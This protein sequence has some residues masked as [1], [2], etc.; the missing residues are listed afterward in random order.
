L[1]ASQA[2]G[3]G[4]RRYFLSADANEGG[5]GLGQQLA[6]RRAAGRRGPARGELNAWILANTETTKAA[7][8]AAAARTKD[9]QR[10]QQL[11]QLARF[12]TISAWDELLTYAPRAGVDLAKIVGFTGTTT[13]PAAARP[14]L[15]QPT[16]NVASGMLAS[17]AEPLASLAP[18]FSSPLTA[19]RGATPTSDAQRST[20]AQRPTSAQKDATQI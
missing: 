13:S 2:R 11:E 15:T 14:A 5:R 9:L 1:I 17:L 7:L 16:R 20:S 19:L 12:V 18:L 6:R 3:G 10:R 4:G 8:Q